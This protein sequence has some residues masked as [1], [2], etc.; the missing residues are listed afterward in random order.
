MAFTDRVERYAAAEGNQPCAAA[1]RDVL[2]FQPE[3][4]GTS[5][6]ACLDFLSRVQHRRAIVFLLSDFLDQSYERLL[7]RTS[8]R[9]DLVMVRISDPRE[10]ELPAVGLLELEDAETGQPLLVDTSSAAVRQAFAQAARRRRDE[11]HQLAGASRVDLIEVSTEGNH[12]DGLV[13][14]FQ[15]RER[16]MR[17]R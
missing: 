8:R 9:H 10:E 13:K 7:K 5:I 3:R 15:M 11:L 6:K 17:R 14:F 2:Y 1:H 12:L 4:Q 16:R